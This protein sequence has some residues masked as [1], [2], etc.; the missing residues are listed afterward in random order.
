MKELM[1]NNDTQD[2]DF[3][4][5][6]VKT[7]V[8]SKISGNKIKDIIFI[9]NSDLRLYRNILISIKNKILHLATFEHLLKSLKK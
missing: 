5:F 1:S 6:I 8:Y 9:K 3:L 4:E 7:I 2:K